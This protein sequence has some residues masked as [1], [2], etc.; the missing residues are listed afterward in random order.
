MIFPALNL[1]SSPFTMDFSIF[2]WG[3]P[4]VFHLQQLHSYLGISEVGQVAP[5]HLLQLFIVI[6]IFGQITSAM[7]I[8]KSPLDTLGA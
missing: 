6:H 2:S 4:V 1:H 5:L 3:F 8:E 7:A